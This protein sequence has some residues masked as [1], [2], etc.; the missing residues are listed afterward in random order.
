MNRRTIIT[1]DGRV[2][3]AAMDDPAPTG[4]HTWGVVRARLVDE[5]SLLPVSA[6]TTIEV[7]QQGL[8]P[9]IVS[10]GLVG[11]VGIPLNVFPALANQ[12]YDVHFTILVS[13]YQ[14]LVVTATIPQ[15]PGFPAAF[16]PT[17]LGDLQVQH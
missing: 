10:D 8:T 2:Y 11:L 14:P 12:S 7:D 13:G 17:D 3:D 1:R 4:A 16:S 6:P 5:V 15:T 9:R